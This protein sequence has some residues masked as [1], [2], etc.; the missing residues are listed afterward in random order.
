MLELE[1]RGLAN[2]TNIVETPGNNEI[3][4]LGHQES[5]TITSIDKKPDPVF[6]IH[7]ADSSDTPGYPQLFSLG[8]GVIYFNIS[9]SNSMDYIIHTAH[10]RHGASGSPLLHFTGNDL[11]VLGVNFGGPRTEWVDSPGY[12]IPYFG[13]RWIQDTIGVIEFASRSIQFGNLSEIERA[14]CELKNL[15]ICEF[16]SQLRDTNWL[17]DTIEQYNF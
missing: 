10:T 15:H 6:L 12:A 1:H 3:T 14:V 2:F 17:E 16:V 4:E 9:N 13:R 11:N 8:D 5:E 7:Y